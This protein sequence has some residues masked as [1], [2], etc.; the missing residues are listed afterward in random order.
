MRDDTVEIP[1]PPALPEYNDPGLLV[2]VLP[3]AGIGI[4]AIFYV[5]RATSTGGSIL[6]AAPMLLMAV[7]IIAGTLMAQ[8]WRRR[9]YERKKREDQINYL[10]LLEKKRTRL[11]AAHDAQIS[12]LERNFPGPDQWLDLAINRSAQLWER[13]PVDPDFIRLRLGLGRVPSMITIKTP[14]ADID[15]DELEQAFALA[16]Q[17]RYLDRAPVL[18]SMHHDVSVG[19]C[20]KRSMVLKS[21]RAMINHLAVTHSPQDLHIHLIAPKANYDDWRWL[22]WLPHASQTN[23]AGSADLLAFDTENIRNLMGNLSQIIDERR[24]RGGEGVKTPHLM[25]IIDGPQLVESEAVYTTILRDGDKV[26]ASALCI[27]NN[28]ESIPTDCGAVV[29]IFDDSRFRYARV[30]R[31]GVQVEGQTADDLSWQDAQHIAR[32]LS[33]VIVREVG[34]GGRIPRRVDFLDVYGARRVEELS[35]QI[36]AR[37]RR[38]ISKGVLPF[39]VKIGRESLAVDTEM[40]LD[41]DHHGPHGMLAGTTGSG[42]SELLQTLI[43]SLVLE[44]DPRLLTLLLI[45]FKGGSTFN[46]FADLP[47]TVGTVTN[48]DGVRV[49]RALEALK[50]ETQWRQHFLESMNVRDITQYHR[51]YAGSDARVRDVNY[52]P[53]P[54]LFIIVDEFA[55]LAKEMPDFMRELVRTVQ[56]GRSLGLHLLLGTQSPMDVITDEMNANLQF[57]I[58]LRV[59]NIEAS[60]AML[61]RPD[62]AYLPAGWPGRGFFQVGEQGMFKQFQTAYVGADYEREE[63]D[64]QVEQAETLVLQMV[65]EDGTLQSLLPETQSVYQSQNGEV[66]PQDI[67]EPYTVARALVDTILSYSQSNNIPQMKPLLLPPLPDVFT[68]DTVMHRVQFGGWDGET[69]QDPGFDH[70]G[71]PIELGSAP[72]GLLDDVYN[73]TQHPLWINMNASGSARGHSKD[74][75]V[76]ILGNPGTGKT[77]FVRTLAISL[78]LLHPP[79]KLHMYFLSFTGTGLDDVGGLPHA[80]KTIYGTETERVRRLFGRLTH[81][82]D[83]RQTVREDVFLPHIVLVIDQYEQ[84]RD[85]YRDQHM[86]DLD[87]ILNEGR[88]VGVYVVLIANSP[89]TIPDRIRSLVQQRIALQL[90]DATDYILAIGRMGAVVGDLPNGRGFY[91]NTPPLA[92]HISLPCRTP[93]IDNEVEAIEELQRIIMRL[94]ISYLAQQG[95]TPMDTLTPENQQN[96]APIEELPVKIPLHSLPETQRSDYQLITPLGRYDDDALSVFNLDWWNQGPHFLVTGPPGSGKTN[97]LQAAVLSAAQQ[98]APSQLRFL[99]VDFNGRSLRPLNGLK[100]V[101]QRVTN[102]LELKTQLV[103][104]RSELNT[105]YNALRDHEVPNSGLTP[106]LLPATVIVIDDYDLTIETLNTGNDQDLLRQL[107]EHVRLHSEMGL[108]IWISGYLERSGD[109]LLKQILLKRSGFGLMTKES[110]HT[111]NIRTVGLP[112]EAMPIGRAYYPQRNSISVVQTALIENAPAYVERINNSLWSGAGRARWENPA[113]A[114]Q[115]RGE[116]EAFLRPSPATQTSTNG[117]TLGLEI[118]VDGLIADLLGRAS[119]DAAG[120]D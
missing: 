101:I 46:V 91:F 17:Y 109:P 108:Y 60:R 36:H 7:V 37:W 18:A 63:K 31:D 23:R 97:F 118:D 12:M 15:S 83:Q 116:A 120:S 105:F 71:E 113:S 9:D 33:A 27:V 51:F 55:Q 41:E 1:A 70:L 96:P 86:R 57:R 52:R 82:L 10:R 65:T 50:A 68:L 53:L 104:L 74:G 25:V 16:D 58:C 107:R 47:H 3:V 28:F 21:M 73:R 44:H 35:S 90:G 103:N 77:M 69:W 87:R 62:A 14:D 94:N 106:P 98:H 8:R 111:L 39:P 61:R 79:D 30:G 84:F 4:M 49:S 64:T 42:K 11:Q 48:L 114:A 99:L 78:A 72:I 119:D 102:T 6:F 93:G 81:I 19:V 76:L 45:D 13:R 56:V 20:G 67:K 95:L 88:A 34:G 29:E 89:T 54:H 5:F 85:T 2:S 59:Q 32:A 80:E 115:I 92:T 75:H 112:N 24:E 100:H 66:T 26:G 117:G 43:C 38:Q 110:L 22:E 40:W